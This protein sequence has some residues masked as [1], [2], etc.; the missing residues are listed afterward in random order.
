MKLARFKLDI[1]GE[2]IIQHDVFNKVVAVVLFVV[3][4][5]QVG[6]SYAQKGDVLISSFV[7][8]LNKSVI[9]VFRLGTKGHIGIAVPNKIV[10]CLV[11]VQ[12]NELVCISYP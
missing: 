2:D 8:A 6:K 5:L 10:I 11:E 12:G 4:L 7:G 1:A 9:F 3:E